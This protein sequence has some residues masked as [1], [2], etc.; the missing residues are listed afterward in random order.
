MSH[1]QARAPLSLF[2]HVARVLVGSVTVTILIRPSVSLGNAAESVRMLAARYLPP[3]PDLVM[4]VRA[5]LREH[6]P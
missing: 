1:L 3:V 6:L 2:P 4:V 5:E